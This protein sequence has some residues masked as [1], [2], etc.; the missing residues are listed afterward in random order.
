MG[1]VDKI[2][3]SFNKIDLKGAYVLELS[4]DPG[5]KMSLTL[6]QDP[7]TVRA[8]GS[9]KRYDLQFN[10]IDGAKM[11]LENSS[12]HVRVESSDARH[13]TAV[14]AGGTSAQRELA[15]FSLSCSS[16]AIEVLASDFSLAVT[17][18]IPIKSVTTP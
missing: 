5:V 17:E 16:G 10:R 2:V 15:V 11:D 7:S 3:D 12:T 8:Q 9:C 1:S 4:L 14:G 13:M 18:E 6:L